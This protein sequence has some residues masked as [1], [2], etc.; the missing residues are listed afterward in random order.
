MTPDSDID[1]DVG[2]DLPKAEE[3]MEEFF[4]V[5]SVDKTGFDIEKYY[6][7]PPLT[8]LLK[9]LF[10]REKDIPVVPE[11]TIRMLIESAKAGRW[12]Y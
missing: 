1:T 7:A 3:L 6:L 11:F 5:F 9:N 10:S 2:I 8:T 12:L 4:D